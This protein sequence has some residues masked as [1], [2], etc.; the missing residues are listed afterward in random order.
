MDIVILPAG[1][2][3][4]NPT[5]FWESFINSFTG[6]K[7]LLRFCE[8]H[9]QSQALKHII[10]DFILILESWLGSKETST[11]DKQCAYM[12]D[13]SAFGRLGKGPRATWKNWKI[14]SLCTWKGKGWGAVEENW[15]GRNPLILCSVMLEGQ[16]PAQAV[17]KFKAWDL[18][19]LPKTL[20]IG[21]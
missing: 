3:Q 17:L 7:C 8:K 1:R 14:I 15:G 9:A 13:T 5:Q 19:M 20:S 4:T 18:C 16:G 2:K 10:T 11:Q 6:L 12:E 21:K